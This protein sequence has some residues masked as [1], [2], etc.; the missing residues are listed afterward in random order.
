[1]SPR[2]AARPDSTGRA[3][4]RPLPGGFDVGP[5]TSHLSP[6]MLPGARRR[7]TRVSRGAIRAMPGQRLVADALVHSALA[8]QTKAITRGV[9]GVF[10]P[11]N[12]C[13]LS[14]DGR[15]PIWLRMSGH[16]A[17]ARAPPPPC[18]GPHTAT[19][20]SPLPQARTASGAT[21]QAPDS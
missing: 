12:V 3:G 7:P 17:V 4:C 10:G 11:W 16:V 20:S 6:P 1:M 9:E 19:M 8:R 2:L 13:A 14:V 5:A 21:S 15:H 18:S